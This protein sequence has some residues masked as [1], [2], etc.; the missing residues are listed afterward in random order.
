MNI[1]TCTYAL[2]YTCMWMCVCIG[3][4]VIVCVCSTRIYISLCVCLSVCACVYVC[5]CVQSHIS[6]YLCKFICV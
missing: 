1:H 6:I 3:P 5:T 4:Y 2:V